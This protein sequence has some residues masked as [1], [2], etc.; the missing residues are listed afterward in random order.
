MADN[1]LIIIARSLLT[2]GRLQNDPE[3]LNNGNPKNSNELVPLLIDAGMVDNLIEVYILL[4]LAYHELNK[5]DEM[6]TMVHTALK[7][8]EPEEFRQLFLDEEIPMSQILIH[9]LAA[10][11]QKKFR[12]NCQAKAL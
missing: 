9:Y 10:L 6:L 7:T 2:Q 3:K 4:S 11:K 5:N 8:A 12:D 1:A